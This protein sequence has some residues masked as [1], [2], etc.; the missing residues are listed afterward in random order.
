MPSNL[1][2][3]GRQ[4]ARDCRQNPGLQ[5]TQRPL[6]LSPK[7]LGVCQKTR[8][9]TLQAWIPHVSTMS[10]RMPLKLVILLPLNC[11]C[12]TGTGYPALQQPVF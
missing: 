6:A 8:R 7:A 12:L 10:L 11:A 5:Q 9:H 3:G 2:I 4:A 1:V